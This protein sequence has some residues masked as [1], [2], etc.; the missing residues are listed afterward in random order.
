MLIMLLLSMLILVLLLLSVLVPVVIL[1]STLMVC[2]CCLWKCWCCYCCLCWCSCCYSCC[3]WCWWCYCC[4][5]WYRCWHCCPYWCWCCSFFV[6]AD[7]HVVINVGVIDARVNVVSVIVLR[8]I[9]ENVGVTV[10]VGFIDV[11]L[12]FIENDIHQRR[13]T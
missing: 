2:Y 1:L 7:A 9:V 11:V 12:I 6:Y 8:V 4:P 13:Q 5:C 10:D 3:L